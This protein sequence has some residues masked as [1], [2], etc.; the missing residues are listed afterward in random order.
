[1]SQAIHLGLAATTLFVAAAATFSDNGPPAVAATT[2]T[3]A[4][5]TRCCR[6]HLLSD[7]LK[8]RG[9]CHSRKLCTWRHGRMR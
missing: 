8:L 5:A 3:I 4:A 7:G 1:M 2:I 9:S 6:V